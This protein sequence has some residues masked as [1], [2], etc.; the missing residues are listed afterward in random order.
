MVQIH[1][2]VPAYFEHVDE[3]GTTYKFPVT[4]LVSYEIEDVFDL[5]KFSPGSVNC[6][7]RAKR[8]FS[9]RFIDRRG[10]C[11]TVVIKAFSKRHARKIAR[12]SERVREWLS[13]TPHSA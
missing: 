2:T 11:R 8:P 10:D 4:R 5:W 1:F 9:V 12:R 6:A 7:K 13:I 3:Y